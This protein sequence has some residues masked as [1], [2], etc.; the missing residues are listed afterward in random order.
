MTKSKKEENLCVDGEQQCLIERRVV[1]V[2][3][4]ALRIFLS[5]HLFLSI[6]PDLKIVLQ[7][8]G[9]RQT[10]NG[11]GGEIITFVAVILDFN[12]VQL[13]SSKRATS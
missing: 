10:L 13:A 2:R 5:H 12:Y 7:C 6:M 4:T 9:R 3:C 1:P 11:R 8:R